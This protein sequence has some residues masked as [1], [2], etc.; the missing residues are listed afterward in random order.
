MRLVAVA[1]YSGEPPNELAR[2][3]TRFVDLLA[4]RC[5][6]S[7]ALLLGGYWGVM[8]IVV[9]RALQRGLTVVVMPPLEREDT[10]F[11]EGCIVIRTG[12]SYRVRSVFLARACDALVALGGASGTMQEIITAYCE[13][14]PVLVLRSGLDTDRLEALAPYIDRRALTRVEFFLTPEGL[15]DRLAEVLGCGKG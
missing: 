10:A 12:T 3:C 2:A 6:K 14:K 1:G 13:G 15:V 8:R 5:G 4:E 11:P 9:D 7:V